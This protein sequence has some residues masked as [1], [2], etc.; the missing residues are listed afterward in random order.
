[1]CQ[2]YSKPKVARFLRHGVYIGF[3]GSCPLTEF[4]PGAKFT[5]VQVLHPLILAA[6]LHGR[7]PNFVAF[8]RGRHLYSAGRPSRWASVH[9]LV[10]TVSVFRNFVCFVF[11]YSDCISYS[12]RVIRYY[13][14]VQLEQ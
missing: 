6:L 3:G 7:Q 4:L 5:S 14:T 8:S 11:G 12:V 1:M 13:I 9:I 2:S 10:V